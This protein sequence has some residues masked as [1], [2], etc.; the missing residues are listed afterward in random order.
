MRKYLVFTIFISGM[1]SLAVEMTASRLLGN[2]FVSS[3]LICAVIVGLILIYLTA[4]YFLGGRWS[5]QSPHFATFYRILAWSGF[6]VGVIPL[7]SRP[8][9]QLAANA[10]DELALGGMVG[11]FVTVLILSAHVTLIGYSLPLRKTVVPFADT[12]PRWLHLPEKS[13]HLH[14]VFVLGTS[15]QACSWSH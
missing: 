12:L 7:V 8:I 15:C 14:P 10:F 5:D 3:N 13:M 6:L 4:G 11:A 2:Y 1:A 9:L